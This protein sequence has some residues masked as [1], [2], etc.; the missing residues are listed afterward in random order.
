MLNFPNVDANDNF[1]VLQVNDSHKLWEITEGK[2]VMMEY[3]GAWQPIRKSGSKFRCI[4]GK[5]V[6][7]GAFIRISDD[8]KKIPK[9]TK[10]DV[11]SSLMV[12]V[13]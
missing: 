3:N 8:W 2:R 5:I 10:E 4:T 11:W 6:R 9:N 1:E 12:C 13:N 7:S